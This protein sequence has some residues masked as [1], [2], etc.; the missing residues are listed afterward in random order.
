[1]KVK[2][3]K[4]IDL[5]EFRLVCLNFYLAK[6]NAYDI[7]VERTYEKYDSISIDYLK[8]LNTFLTTTLARQYSYVH[9]YSHVTDRVN[10]TLVLT[11]NTP[12]EREVVLKKLP[13]LILMHK[14]SY[15]E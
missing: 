4:V 3:T 11:F 7:Y 15:V 6:R 8:S 13:G 1:M 5:I 2:R 12:L 10:L 14:L 9:D